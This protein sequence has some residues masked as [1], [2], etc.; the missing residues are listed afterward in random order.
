MRKVEFRF[1][2]SIQISSVNQ[3]SCS[4]NNSIIVITPLYVAHFQARYGCA[5]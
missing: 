2:N 3:G 4:N 1:F 5:T